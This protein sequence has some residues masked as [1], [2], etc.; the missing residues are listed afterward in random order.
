MHAFLTFLFASFRDWLN[1][2]RDYID[3]WL[4]GGGCTPTT[5]TGETINVTDQDGLFSGGD[6]ND[7]ITATR[8][9]AGATFY[10]DTSDFYDEDDFFSLNGTWRGPGWQWDPSDGP[11]PGTGV[12]A[13]LTALQGGA[14]N[15]S[16]TGTGGGIDIDG[17]AGNDTIAG[18]STI[19]G[20]DTWG[21]ASHIF[22]RGGAGDDSITLTGTAGVARG[23]DGNDTLTITGTNMNVSGNAGDDRLTL[24]GSGLN[25]IAS[26]GADRVDVTNLTNSRIELDADDTLIRSD[27]SDGL[28]FFLGVGTSFTGNAS[29]ETMAS[30]G[31]V[32]IDAAGGNDILG[33]E[34][35]ATLSSTLRGGAG[36]DTISGNYTDT[37]PWAHELYTHAMHVGRTDDVLQ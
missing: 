25:V 6:N 2:V 23:G 21:A 3:D 10:L 19:P 31:G 28:R 27:V 17:G 14:G 12:L 26:A 37:F 18:H 24:S 15:D 22:A 11:Y 20:G 34:E 16:I 4:G 32:G 33:L 36:D 8:D 29:N 13:G 5:P 30:M 1:T 9:I 7:T 35:W